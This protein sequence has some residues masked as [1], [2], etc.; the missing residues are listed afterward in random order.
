MKMATILIIVGIIGIA[1]LWRFGMFGIINNNIKMLNSSLNSSLSSFY[2][3][4]G[5]GK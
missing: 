3:G 1:V 5:Y 2:G 4:Y